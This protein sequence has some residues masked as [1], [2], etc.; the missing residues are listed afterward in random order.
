V[1][2]SPLVVPV[3]YDF[4]SSIGFVA[5]R[6]MQR[7]E[8]FL[9]DLGLEL[10]WTAIDLAAL[11]G[12]KRHA[13]IEPLRR[14][15]ALRVARELSVD[16]RMPRSWLDSRDVNAVAHLAAEPGTR[17]GAEASWRERVWSAIF[18][19]GGDPSDP[20][21]FGRLASAARDLGV[22]LDAESP[23]GEAG[24][25]AGGREALAQATRRAADL[26]VTGVPTFMLG[27]WPVGGIQ[28]EATM[29]S[30]LSRFARKRRETVGDRGPESTGGGIH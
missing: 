21:V 4:A 23:A 25:L 27:G 17:P 1:S 19:E 15:N 9:R 2:R 28:E 13:E 26:Q 8:P 3:Y 22:R 24:V 18:E 12:W 29:R 11:L 30:L 7:M 6:V 10:R 16:L 14:Q 5:H 20:A